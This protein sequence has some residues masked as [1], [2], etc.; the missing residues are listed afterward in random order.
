M[1]DVLGRPLVGWVLA[2]L[3]A[4]GVRHA[5]VNAAWLA[6]AFAGVPALGRSLGIDVA[7]SIQPEPLEHGGDLAFADAF[8][9]R[10]EPDEV[11]LAVNGDT[12]IEID[13]PALRAAA[14]TVTAAAPLAILGERASDGALRVTPEGRLVGIGDVTYV[15]DAGPEERWDD[16]GI[17]LL[18]ASVRRVMPPPGTRMSFHGA[19]GLV[20]RLVAAGLEVRVAPAPIRARAEIGTV[21]EYEARE[22]NESLRSITRRLENR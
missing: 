2:G 14:A 22:S 7:L 19:G 3:A 11:F 10:L 5:T 20:G 15:P 17:K 4:A 16:S 8:L 21:A 6:D 18:H 1:L 9:D 12:I 13:T